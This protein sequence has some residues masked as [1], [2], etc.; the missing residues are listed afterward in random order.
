MAGNFKD[1]IVWQKA[2]SLAEQIYDATESFPKHELYG[3]TNQVRRAAISVPSNI[4]EGQSRFSKRDFRHFL[5]ER[6]SLAEIGTQLVI[7]CRRKYLTEQQLNHL[8]ANIDEVGR[9][10]NGLINSL[11]SVG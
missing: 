11:A 7:A 2:I 5:R 6:G 10:P 3:L 4:A 8:V 9:I 1:L